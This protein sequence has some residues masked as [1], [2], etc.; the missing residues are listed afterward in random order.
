MN[1]K[2]KFNNLAQQKI[3]QKKTTISPQ[4]PE[5]IPGGAVPPCAKGCHLLLP[6][7][8]L[9]PQPSLSGSGWQLPLTLNVQLHVK[10]T[11]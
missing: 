9:E 4:T 1:H 11:E 10:F 7:I 3:N 2:R 5:I 6:T 8:Y